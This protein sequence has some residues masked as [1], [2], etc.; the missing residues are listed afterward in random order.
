MPGFPL[1]DA[2]VHLVEPE[3]FSYG[4]TAEAPSLYRRLLPEHFLRAAAPVQIERFVFVEVDVDPPHH[5]AEAEWV[6]EVAQQESRLAGMVASLPLE[7][8]AAVAPELETLLQHKALRGIRRLI[9]GKPAGF[10][11]APEFIA[12]L[13]LLAPHDLSFDICVT[14]DQMPDAIEM[15]RRCPD[16]RF[17]LDHIGKPAI[18]H[19]L[20]D[21]WRDHMRELAAL[22][23]V[24]CKISGV[25]TEADHANWTRDQLRP[26]IAH[27]IGCFGFDRVMFGGDWHVCELAVQYPEW[28]AL[29][30]WVL[31]GVSEEN[32]RK[33]YRDN[34]ISFYRLAS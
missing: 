1:V 27:A 34:A 16:V 6:T 8:G 22:P 7:H 25:A 11:V 18:R 29:L 12:G 26:Y 14:H 23:N 31:E 20:L 13:K 17:V 2:H 33:L 10:C 32:K 19:E 15:A 4:W 30:D 9:Q 3:R 21:P 5:L 24:W 28:V